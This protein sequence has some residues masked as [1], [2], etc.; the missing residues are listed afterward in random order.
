M[1]PAQNLSFIINEISDIVQ[2]MLPSLF[3]LKCF[4]YCPRYHTYFEL[5]CQLLISVQIIV[6]L[7][8]EGEELR[9]FGHP[10]REMVLGEDRELGTL[11]SGGSYEVGCFRE[12]VGGVEGLWGSIS[13]GGCE[14]QA[15]L[16][17]MEDLGVELDE[18]NLV[19]GCHSEGVYQLFV[20]GESGGSEVEAGKLI[21]LRRSLHRSSLIL[22]GLEAKNPSN[23]K[24]SHHQHVVKNIHKQSL[25]HSTNEHRMKRPIVK[26]PS[27]MNR[28]ER[29]KR[30][31]KTTKSRCTS[32]TG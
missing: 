18:G 19:M 14:D 16:M 4:H 12:V 21:L 3:I 2:L 31:W 7:A 26:M 1:I 25:W 17:G 22:V 11:G 27:K 30:W 24:T 5:F 20:L 32:T 28:T 15:E 9:V 6:P 29:R 23:A 8:A 13:V 10:V